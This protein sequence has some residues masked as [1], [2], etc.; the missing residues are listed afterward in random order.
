MVR[1]RRSW[2]HCCLIFHVC[3][4]LIMA[5]NLNLGLTSSSEIR[6][7]RSK[8]LNYFFTIS[9]GFVSLE[10]EF[11]EVRFFTSFS[12]STRP[13]NVIRALLLAWTSKIEQFKSLNWL[14]SH[15]Q[16]VHELRSWIRWSPIFRVCFMLILAQHRN[17]D[18]TP[19]SI[20]RIDRFQSLK[21]FFTIISGSWA[22][23]LNS[24]Q[25]N[26]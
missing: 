5:Q 12:C 14:F 18:L 13:K 26:F 17:L 11:L 4:Q 10:A 16:G 22:Q 24:S 1:E 23:K 20:I 2:N 6:I 7:Q 3:V 8:G 21:C 9:K 15:F 19:I 25:P